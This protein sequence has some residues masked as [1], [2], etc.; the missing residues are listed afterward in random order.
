M[1]QRI[2]YY[3]IFRRA[4]D[5]KGNFIPK[6]SFFSLLVALQIEQL[7]LLFGLFTGTFYHLSKEWPQIK[8]LHKC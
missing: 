3:F 2:L 8:C 4:L 6:S 1:L 7:V 5:L